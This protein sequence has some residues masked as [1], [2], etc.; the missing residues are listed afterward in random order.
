VGIDDDEK[1]GKTFVRNVRVLPVY[2]A[3]RRESTTDAGTEV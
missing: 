2:P 3:K 1:S